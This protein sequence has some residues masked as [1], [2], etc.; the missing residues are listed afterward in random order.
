MN[1]G[2][3]RTTRPSS[4]RKFNLQ[5][6]MMHLSTIESIT[7]TSGTA[8]KITIGKAMKR[9]GISTKRES[10]TLGMTRRPITRMKAREPMQRRPSK[11]TS[12]PSAL[13]SSSSSPFTASVAS[14]ASQGAYG[15]K[16]IKNRLNDRLSRLYRLSFRSPTKKDLN[17]QTRTRHTS[18]NL[19][20]RTRRFE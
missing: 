3:E 19:M 2:S 9:T 4:T 7:T 16:L 6:T 8:Q 1:R 17:F 13:P 10:C 15:I 18:S 5:V 12:S 20:I 14:T 11:F